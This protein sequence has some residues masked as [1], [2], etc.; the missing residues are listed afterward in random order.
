MLHPSAR[1]LAE[2]NDGAAKPGTGEQLEKVIQKST[3]Q[4]ETTYPS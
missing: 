1:Q 2:E 3:E 4:K